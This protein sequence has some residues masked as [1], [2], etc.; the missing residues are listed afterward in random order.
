MRRLLM[1]AAGVAAL[2]A[3]VVQPAHADCTALAGNGTGGWHITYNQLNWPIY[4]DASWDRIVYGWQEDDP[5][6]PAHPHLQ[7]SIQVG[8]LPPRTCVDVKFDWDITYSTQHHDAR[9]LRE[10]DDFG[11]VNTNGV[12]HEQY[13]PAVRFNGMRQLV[14]YL[15]HLPDGADYGDGRCVPE[16]DTIREHPDMDHN[17]SNQEQHLNAP[18]GAAYAR[19]WYEGPAGNEYLY[20]GGNPWSPTS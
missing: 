4:V 15:C 11:S 13:D 1:I 16:Y 5:D 14:V 18:L 9:Y 10:C 20:S 8:A 19:F 3:G 12:F 6:K 2:M 7:M 17:C